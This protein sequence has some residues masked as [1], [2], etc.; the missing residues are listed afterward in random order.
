[1]QEALRATVDILG[2]DAR[3][4][5]R[6][7]SIHEVVLLIMNDV[8]GVGISSPTPSSA[9]LNLDPPKYPSHLQTD[10]DDPGCPERK[11]I[12]QLLTVSP[13]PP[14]GNEYTN[15]CVHGLPGLAKQQFAML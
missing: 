14:P 13:G 7:L 5:N 12:D 10:M 15:I 6:H 11:I 4:E 3:Q 8:F 9:R 1:M 2:I